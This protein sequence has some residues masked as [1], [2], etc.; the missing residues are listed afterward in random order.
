MNLGKEKFHQA[1]VVFWPEQAI[2][3]LR[4]PFTVPN[5]ARIAEAYEC[6]AQDLM[7]L[8]IFFLYI[9]KQKAFHCH[10]LYET[11]RGLAAFYRE[12]QQVRA[13]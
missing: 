9:D 10:W 7:T 1:L 4:D 3:P 8:Y 5:Y 2:A 6:A 12:Q 11:A 13:A